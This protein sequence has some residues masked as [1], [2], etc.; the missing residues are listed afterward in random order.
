M[1]IQGYLDPDGRAVVRL[2][3]RGAGDWRVLA[4]E[5]DTGAKPE[6]VT[7]L[8]WFQELD[9]LSDDIPYELTL[10]DGRVIAAMSALVE[11]E[12]LGEIRFA[13][14]MYPMAQADTAPFLPPGRRGPN[15][16]ALLGRL[17]L[18]NCRLTIDYGRAS[19]TV[20]PSGS[21]PA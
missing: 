15:T 21:S 10:A 12:W 16:N 14:M 19:V 1:N 17:L 18:A 9:A 20:E 4:C 7:S 5:I 11:V 13:S 6:L 8:D 3:I 2:R